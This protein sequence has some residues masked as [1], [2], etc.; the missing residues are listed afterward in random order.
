VSGYVRHAP[1]AYGH[2]RNMRGTR[3]MATERIAMACQAKQ[4]VAAGR[5]RGASSLSAGRSISR[6]SPSGP[7]SPP[8]DVK[9]RADSLFRMSSE[10]DTGHGVPRL[11]RSTGTL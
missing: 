3:R 8:Y 1:A 4:A 5:L 11:W 10:P 6:R 7:R 2:P 9:L